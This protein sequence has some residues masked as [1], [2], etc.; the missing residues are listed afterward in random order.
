MKYLKLSS[1]H[2]VEMLSNHLVY[3]VNLPS[4]SCTRAGNG[5]EPAARPCLRGAV[6][7]ELGELA[8]SPRGGASS[9]LPRVSSA[10]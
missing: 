1:S 4:K 10:S 7:C 2:M 8:A 6:V 3:T 5:G 9:G